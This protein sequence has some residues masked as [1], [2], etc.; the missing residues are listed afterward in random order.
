MA[1]VPAFDLSKN[2]SSYVGNQSTKTDPGAGQPKGARTGAA[3]GRTRGV[4]HPIAE[5]MALIGDTRHGLHYQ[6]LPKQMHPYGQHQNA[7]YPDAAG[8]LSGTDQYRVDQ[9]GGADKDL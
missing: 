3:P 6:G 1:K 8:R 4:E 7:G 5:D 9:G 2:N